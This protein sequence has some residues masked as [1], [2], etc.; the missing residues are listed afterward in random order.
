MQNDK[1]P[2]PAVVNFAKTQLQQ[3]PPPWG[4]IEVGAYYL[5]WAVVF[6]NGRGFR[7]V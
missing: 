6:S 7:M 1:K 2:P 3:L 5:L 4:R